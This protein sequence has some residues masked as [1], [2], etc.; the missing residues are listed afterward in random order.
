MVVC[1]MLC[2]GGLW[3]LLFGCWLQLVLG[4]LLLAV[5]CVVVAVACLPIVYYVYGCYFAFGFVYWLTL[6]LFWLDWLDGCF[7]W[8]V[9]TLC[10]WLRL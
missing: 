10:A 4:Q 9:L 5:I 3:V 1:I 8:L 2:W 6:G 7:C